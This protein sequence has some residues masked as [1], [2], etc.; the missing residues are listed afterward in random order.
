MRAKPT[1]TGGRPARHGIVQHI[2]DAS[3]VMGIVQGVYNASKV[4]A[5]YVRPVLAA[6]AAAAV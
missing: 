1:D 2:E 5:Q 4:I 6:M 3:N